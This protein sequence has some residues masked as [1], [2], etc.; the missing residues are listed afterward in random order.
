MTD[1]PTQLIPAPRMKV[2]VRET[3]LNI[4]SGSA[5]SR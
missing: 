2:H 3:I 4:D 1:E 5:H